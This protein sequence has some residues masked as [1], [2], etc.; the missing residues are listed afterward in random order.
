MYS[1]QKYNAKSMGVRNLL[2][3]STI[4]S[5]D[6]GLNVADTDLNMA[7]KFAKVLDNM[8]RGTDGTLS[9]RPGTK[10][11][12]KSANTTDIINIYYFNNHVITVHANGAIYKITGAGV[13]TELFQ[14][15]PAPANSRFFTAGVYFVSFT[16]FSSDLIIANGKDKPVIVS[17]KP[18]DARY[19][20]GEY[21][22]DKATGSNVNTP[23]GL[24]V[25]AHG[26][27]TIMGGIAA[28]PSTIY[29]SA[30]GTSG[31]WV[32]DPAPNDAIKIDLG[33]RVSLGSATVTGMVA[34][35]DKLLIMFER[36]VLPMNMGVY[37]G[38][39][40][41]HVPTDD[42]FIEEFGGL[43]HRSL[44]SVGDDTFYNDNIGINSI[45]RISVFNT[46]RPVR[47]S[48]LV[49]P[50]ITAALKPL[51]QQQI[52]RN[53]F[54]VYD[55]RNFRY[56]IFIPSFEA[57]GVTIKESVGFSY[58]NIPTLDVKA[59]A[60]LRGWKWRSSCR[61]ALQNILF[62][63]GNKIYSYDFDNDTENAD[64]LSDP[65]IETGTGVA[66]AFEWELPWADFKQRMEIKQMRYIG[67]DTQ[68]NATF[69]LE[70]Y[71]DNILRFEGA[72]AP[73]LSMDFIGGDAAGYGEGPY[74][75]GPYGG[76]RNT[77][78]ERLFAYVAKF[79]L[80]KLRVHGLSKKNLKFISI[81]V[82]YMRGSIRR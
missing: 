61:T 23:I 31:T 36:G 62:T 2:T 54:A 39:P 78:E 27:F 26:Q 63:V 13:E 43:S 11:F 65:E 7:P 16:I 42:G 68:G 33:P 17:G 59:W 1:N 22:N 15:S 21:L 82:A 45:A 69:T 32:S 40:A 24:F 48:Q 18:A 14:P 81:S 4:R 55:M 74:G 51:T 50:L 58:T 47:I 29:V 52:A 20:L 19:M 34:Y 49:D 9:V 3:F 28:E 70:G 5:F 10:F 12:K 66:V 79:K 8:E 6:G 72:D 80:L 64:F 77:S 73:L 53:V 67:L 41:V 76:G 57:D 37:T 75:D 25:I 35:R 46:L 71:V 44:V 30:K 56:I 60:R 38:T